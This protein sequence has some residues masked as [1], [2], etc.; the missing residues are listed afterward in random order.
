MYGLLGLKGPNY[1]THNG[2]IIVHNVESVDIK[3]VVYEQL[4]V[5]SSNVLQN[6][7]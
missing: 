4:L 6:K 1:C 5:F 7:L 2:S 3:E